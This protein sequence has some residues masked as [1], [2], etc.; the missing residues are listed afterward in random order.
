MYD[1]SHP[2]AGGDNYDRFI[3]TGS[4]TTQPL[5]GGAGVGTGGFATTEDWSTWPGN[6]ESTLDSNPVPED[7]DNTAI[8][9][10][11]IPL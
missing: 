10:I 3:G 9:R 1:A 5:T 2:K 6:A 11:E 7:T 4:D 8:N